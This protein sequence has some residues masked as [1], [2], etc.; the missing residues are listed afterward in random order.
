MLNMFIYIVLF[1]TSGQIL[2]LENDCEVLA[3]SD[4]TGYEDGFNADAR[5]QNITAIGMW[6]LDELVV[7]DGSCIR[8]VSMSDTRTISGSCYSSGSRTGSAEKSRFNALIDIAVS[9]ESDLYGFDGET[10][11]AI[12][13]NASGYSWSLGLGIRKFLSISIRDNHMV[14]TSIHEIFN[15]SVSPMRCT[16]IA[17]EDGTSGYKDGERKMSWFNKP[18][19]GIYIQ[20][21]IIVADTNNYCLRNISDSNTGTLYGVCETQGN[22]AGDDDYLYLPTRLAATIYG[23]IIVSDTFNLREVDMEGNGSTLAVF[24][25]TI[26]DI[27]VVGNVLY[28]AFK[29]HIMRCHWTSMTHT[30]LTYV[31]PS[32]HEHYIA[33][34][35]TV[36]IVLVVLAIFIGIYMFFKCGR[37]KRLEKKE[38]VE[39]TGEDGEKEKK[40][41]VLIGD[42]VEESSNRDC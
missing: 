3:G 1:V 42:G 33:T 23:T 2:D 16:I 14:M 28:V 10:N 39:V 22:Y 25:E 29:H 18:H 40:V 41:V 26:T 19:D 34:L 4:R 24:N 27:L 38:K 6:L 20:G 17:G 31:S 9:V 37:E 35:M 30:M 32:I 13:V 11:V 8:G 12:G 15:C 7:T 21:G 36:T 5:F